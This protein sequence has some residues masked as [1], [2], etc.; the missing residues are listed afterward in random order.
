MA[1]PSGSLIAWKC[2]YISFRTA[3]FQL[4]LMDP[5]QNWNMKKASMLAIMVEGSASS[6]SFFPAR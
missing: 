1:R 6:E 3:L 4:K 5:Y 2:P